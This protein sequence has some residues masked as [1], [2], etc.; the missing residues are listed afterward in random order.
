MKISIDQAITATG[1]V[2]FSEVGVFSTTIYGDT[3]LKGVAKQRDMA[4]RIL[5]WIE[6]IEAE[7]WH[8][9]ITDV[10]YEDFI[11]YIPDDRKKAIVALTH[12][13]GYLLAKLEEWAGNRDINIYSV[14]KGSKSKKEAAMVA[15][16]DGLKG[17][18]HEYDAY[19]QGLLAW[20]ENH[21][22]H[23]IY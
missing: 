4:N 22:I 23:Q 16:A 18:E 8:D 11:K 10:V 9:P 19:Y 13:S 14:C 2:A 7:I 17:T 15:T 20:Q 3:K 5:K 21:D 6:N 12:F 1:I